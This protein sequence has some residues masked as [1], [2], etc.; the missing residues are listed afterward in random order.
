MASVVVFWLPATARSV[1][2][3]VVNSHWHLVLALMFAFAAAPLSAAELFD[4]IIR[5]GRVADG[6]G[7]PAFFADVA[8]KDGRI[9]ALGKI[10]GETRMEIDA[11]GLTIAPG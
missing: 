6:T 1:T 3:T 8:V 10:R 4:L 11:A 9:A 5:H 2:L 7:N